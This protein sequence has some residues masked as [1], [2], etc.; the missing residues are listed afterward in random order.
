MDCN[1]A[2]VSQLSDKFPAIIILSEQFDLRP[3]G[4]FLEQPAEL[5]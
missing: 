2:I 5:C 1:P 4:A 3:I